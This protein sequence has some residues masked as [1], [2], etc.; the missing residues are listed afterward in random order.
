MTSTQNTEIWTS[1]SPFAIATEDDVAA[2]W[3]KSVR[4]LQRWRTEG[5]GPPYIRIGG[6]VHYLVSD[7][8]AFEARQRRGGEAQR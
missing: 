8:L 4:T 7:V 6:T 3:Q 2:R 5:Y 1:G